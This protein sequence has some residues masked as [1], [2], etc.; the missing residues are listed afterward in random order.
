MSCVLVIFSRIL[1][2]KPKGSIYPNNL[3]N[4]K[5]RSVKSV[6]YLSIALRISILTKSKGPNFAQFWS[7]PNESVWERWKITQRGSLIHKGNWNR[8]SSQ[9][10]ATELPP[11]CYNFYWLLGCYFLYSTCPQIYVSKVKVI[12]KYLTLKQLFPRKMGARQRN[13]Q[14]QLYNA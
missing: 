8:N 11:D 7:K 9:I 10:F 14:M 12:S 13:S 6:H 1:Q 4:L 2:T 3:N 5:T